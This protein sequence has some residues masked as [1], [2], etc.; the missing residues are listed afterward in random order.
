M[1]KG[2]VLV[3][4]DEQEMLENYSRLLKRIG[5]ECIPESDSTAVVHGISKNK[6]TSDIVL[7]DLKM[8][9][10][11]GFDI[12]S[13]SLQAN[14]E[15]PVI[16]V[17]AFADITTAVEAVKRGAFDF[18]AKPFSTDQLMITLERAIKQKNIA[19]EN[20][21][22]K[23]QL[24][25]FSSGAIVGKSSVMQ[26]LIAIS[27]RIS[28]T[29]ASILITGESGTGKELVSRS[30]HKKS[31]RSA[32]PFI[33]VDCAALPE[34]LLESELFGYEKGAFTGAVSAKPGLFEAA[35]GG[36][37]FLDE[38]GEMAIQMQVKLLRA[39]QERQVRRLGSNKF[40]PID[41]RVISATNRDLKQSV[42]DRIFR[43]DLFYRL[44]VINLSVPPLRDRQ[45]DI[46]I[47]CAYFLEKFAVIYKK[48][49]RSLSSEAMEY[50]ERYA[51]PGNV[52]ELQNVIERAVVLSD[53]DCI[54]I[55]ELPKELIT[56]QS[57]ILMHDLPYKKAKRAWMDTFEK[58][59]LASILDKTDGNISRAAV[60]AGI[61]RKTIHRLIVRHDLQK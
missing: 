25:F 55:K 43:E 52:R 13:A 18:I 24:Q 29:D 30:I 42:A 12:L 5:Y 17:T 53:G 32:H 15:V 61:D 45:G 34:T 8:P 23:E 22:L 27:E 33:P 10:K 49:T 58:N 56:G 59:Y 16:V 9:G 1:T 20:R 28:Q 57:S 39:L 51:W 7:T 6:Y 50:M 19:D 11:D 4:E 40:I 14:P 3:I 41:V 54:T 35:Q 60:M 37:L 21:T 26:E 38:I 2:R 31:L 36:T 46:P 47:L 44:N 48:K